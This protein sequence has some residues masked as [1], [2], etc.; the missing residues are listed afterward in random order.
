[1]ITFNL[2]NAYRPIS[3]VNFSGALN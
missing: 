1:L 2:F 3:V